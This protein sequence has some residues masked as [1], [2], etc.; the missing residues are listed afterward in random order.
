MEP[1]VEQLLTMY[2]DNAAPA[3]ECVSCEPDLHGTRAC[4]GQQLTC[5]RPHP[6]TAG[7]HEQRLSA[8]SA[9]KV[10]RPAQ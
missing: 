7:A 10:R 3:V 4:A 1:T 9:R 2:A 6:H 8:S 5:A